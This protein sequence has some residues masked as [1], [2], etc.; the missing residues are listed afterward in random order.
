ML[1]CKHF[2]NYVES[3]GYEVNSYKIVMYLM[4]LPLI[5]YIWWI[6][7]LRMIIHIVANCQRL[8]IQGKR[9]YNK[10]NLLMMPENQH[11]HSVQAYTVTTYVTWSGLLLISKHREMTVLKIQCVLTRQRL[12]LHLPN[13]HTLYTNSLPSKPSTVQESS[14]Q[15]SRHFR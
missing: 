8:A 9:L 12:Q 10:L 7:L 15:I 14:C 3:F 1:V 6:D 4:C 5:F 13:F 11:A 2:A